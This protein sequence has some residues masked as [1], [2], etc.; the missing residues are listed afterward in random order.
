MSFFPDLLKTLYTCICL[1]IFLSS[2]IGLLLVLTAEAKVGWATSILF[3]S[4]SFYLIFFISFRKSLNQLRDGYTCNLTFNR[5]PSNCTGTRLSYRSAL[6]Q[7]NASC[8]MWSARPASTRWE[9][10]SRFRC[11]GNCWKTHHPVAFVPQV[12]HYDSV[13][14]VTTEESSFFMEMAAMR[15]FRRLFNYIDGGN[16]KGVCVFMRVFIHLGFQ[17]NLNWT[18]RSE[19]IVFYDDECKHAA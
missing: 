14:W 6:R 15:A 17:F 5:F 7:R 2:I 18:S 13:K 3:F 11:R 19:I 16:E 10:R 1:R 4:L 9:V 12:R 8:L